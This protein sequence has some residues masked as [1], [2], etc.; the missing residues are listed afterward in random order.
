MLRNTSTQWG[1]LSR[2]FHWVLGV[3]IIGMIAYGWWMNHIPA[4]ADRFFYR[5]VHA[6][7]GYVVLVLTVIRM[8]WRGVNPRP[9]WPADIPPWLR[10]VARIKIEIVMARFFETLRSAAISPGSNPGDL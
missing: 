1:S 7:I 5:S 8:I 9:D 4:R 6:D 3:A 10:I 2:W